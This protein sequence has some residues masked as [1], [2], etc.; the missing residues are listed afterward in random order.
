[1]FNPHAG[2]SSKASEQPNKQ[3]EDL[4]AA[5][6][7]A[8]QHHDTVEL[9]NILAKLPFVHIQTLDGS[10][11]I[12]N[13]P[14]IDCLLFE[15]VS[16][17]LNNKNTAATIK[18]LIKNRANILSQRDYDLKTP[19]IA[20]VQAM[21]QPAV[22]T[23]LAHNNSKKYVNTVDGS[24]KSAIFY[25]CENRSF[26]QERA[27][28]ADLLI[29][30][31]ADL[32][33]RSYRNMIPAEYASS[34]TCV[35]EATNA[36]KS[37]NAPV[38]APSNI[39][40]S[41]DLAQKQMNQMQKESEAKQKK[42][43]QMQKES[44]AK[45]KKMSQMQ[46]ELEV[47]QKQLQLMLSEHS[48]FVNS[49]TTLFN[50]IGAFQN[51]INQLIIQINVHQHLISEQ[52]HNPASLNNPTVRNSYLPLWKLAQDP[53]QPFDS[54]TNPKQKVALIDD[55]DNYDYDNNNNNNRLKQ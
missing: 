10:T 55:D 28:I 20:A 16:S 7:R 51:E 36:L 29:K 17:H 54:N 40:L 32:M 22:E 26:P 23:L 19:L 1:M 50:S 4:I 30:N 41:C 5:A 3:N 37:M 38:V 25:T 52:Q 27:S 9:K 12:W 18:L 46:K 13:L 14:L 53:H 42:M 43:S 35:T 15:A 24:K 2:K 34:P 49:A 21:E 31:N 44:E 39:I 47:K 8:T 45:Q 48:E 11:E 6:F 33:Q